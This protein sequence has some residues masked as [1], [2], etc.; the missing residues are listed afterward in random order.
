MELSVF[1]MA[2][3]VYFLLKQPLIFKLI[4]VLVILLVP[5]VGYWVYRSIFLPSAAMPV[6][7]LVGLRAKVVR[8]DPSGREGMLEHKGELWSFV[9]DTSMGSGLLAEGAYVRVVGFDGL[10]LKVVADSDLGC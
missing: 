9:R 10:K 8:L 1:Q 4:L 5:L 7:E 2:S 3:L 6:E